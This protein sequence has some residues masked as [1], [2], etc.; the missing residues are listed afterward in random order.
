MSAAVAPPNF[1]STSEPLGAAVPPFTSHA[2]SVSLPTWRDNIG[3]E[4]GEKRVADAMVTGYP[5]FFIHRS[6]QKLAAICEQKFGQGGEKCLLCPS[7]RVAEHCRA[8]ILDRLAK[9]GKKGHVRLVQYFIAS[10]PPPSPTILKHQRA[11]SS[12][13][14]TSTSNG[15]ADTAHRSAEIHIALFQPDVFPYAKQFWQH[16]GMI[17]SSRLAEHCLTLLDASSEPA[18]QAAP[19]SPTTPA[20]SN[21]RVAFKAPNRHYSVKSTPKLS[22][23]SSSSPVF[24]TTAAQPAPSPSVP[25]TTPPDAE[26]L[27]RD[28]T[29]YL[30]ERY[31]RN[32]PLSSAPHAK[33]ALRRRIAGVLLHDDSP[34]P[35][36][37]D[38]DDAIGQ[39]GAEEPLAPLGPSS[40]GVPGVTEH[41]VFL[42]PT[43]MSAIWSAHQLALGAAP[44]GVRESAKS[45][46]FGFPYTDTL[47]ILE[48]WGPGCYFL[49]HGL[50]EDVDELERIL[51]SPSSS[52]N[53]SEN[54]GERPI[55]ALFTE[56]PSN[57]LLRSA[58]LPRLRALADKHN[59]I[60]VVD[61][62]IGNFLNVAVLPHADIV[63]S[64]L[65]KIFSGD[66]NAMG[67]ALVLNPA[68]AHY[69]ALK[70]TMGAQYEDVYWA[71]DALFMERNSR[72][73]ARRVRRVDENTLAVC[74][75]LHA[76][77]AALASSSSPTSSLPNENTKPPIINQVF[78]PKYITPHNYA[79]CRVLS[80]T[81]GVPEGGY[82]G[83]FSLT[84]TSL[85]A[86]R[87]FFDAL[88]CMKGPSLGTNFTLACP[89]TILAHY[90]ELPWAAGWGVE[91]G[92]VRVSIGLEERDVLLSW[93]AGALEAAER[94]TQGEG[95]AGI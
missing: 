48:K 93:F 32:L 65:S 67:G 50:D 88:P 42:F 38:A 85:L 18:S 24:P 70:R 22:A 43:G 71:E 90:A 30:E 27:S 4:E 11:G 52:P 57:P 94:A 28:Q 44:A 81:T 89:Y 78:Y 63:V 16:C 58:P 61:D 34:S 69:P 53:E 33:R 87:A 23:S 45:V 39:A 41:D 95:E 62:T 80:P 59:F 21:S 15:D 10:S 74:E 5:R 14:G 20:F 83:L 64:S 49:G 82:G 26:S 46:C 84:F 19:A 12:S 56:F 29:M 76:R 75:F 79:T 77:S 13:A 35:A 47:K 66:A 73:F 86:S 72:D 91:E 1:A 40:R 54:D 60:L 2:I 51:A 68:G 92:L 31:G 3:Y 36:P 17:V 8:F 25:Q 55:L 37:S 7:R 9:E 6:V